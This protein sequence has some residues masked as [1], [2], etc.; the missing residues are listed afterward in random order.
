ME[1][2]IRSDGSRYAKGM[3]K[4]YLI[5]AVLLLCGC[6]QN[7]RIPITVID[8]TSVDT[9]RP[10]ISYLIVLSNESEQSFYFF[11][12]SWLAFSEDTL[13]LESVYKPS[14]ND[15]IRF[16]F[17]QFNPPDLIEVKPRSSITRV[18]NFGKRPRIPAIMGLRFYKRG[19]PYNPK[20]DYD[21]YHSMASF[22]SFEDTNSFCVY[23]RITLR[24]S[25]PSL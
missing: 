10:K 9:L 12:N 3:M 17:N 25:I 23:S 19:Y 2:L 6:R 22:L 18:L 14:P 21:K 5:V 4:N 20:D 13:M 1:D 8:E 7:V 11:T 16:S 15:L 24:D